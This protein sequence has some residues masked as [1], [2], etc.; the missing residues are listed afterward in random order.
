[1]LEA[2]AREREVEL[3]ARRLDRLLD[4]RGGRG[5]GDTTVVAAPR[6]AASR[7]GCARGALLVTY[8]AEHVA[9]GLGDT[10]ERERPLEATLWGEPRGGRALARL[11]DGTEVR[12]TRGEWSVTGGRDVAYAMR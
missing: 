5:D 2:G 7:S 12:W 9:A 4:R 8:P 11:A 1:M 3:P 10:P 6:S